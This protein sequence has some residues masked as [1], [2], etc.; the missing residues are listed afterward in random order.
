MQKSENLNEQEQEYN[1]GGGQY[2]PLRYNEEETERL[3]K[4]AYGGIPKRDGKRG[5]RHLQRQ[6]NRWHK[7]RQARKISKK[8]YGVKQHERRMLK[9]SAVVR[10]VKQMKLDAVGIREHEA[11]YQGA[12]A[13][14]WT[15]VM[16]GLDG[17]DSDGEQQE[18]A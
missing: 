4:E 1:V 2:P 14:R 9:R 17:D 13:A 16:L 12:V 18:N 11:A 8:N 6:S 10:D 7:V 3:L 15:Q 5:T